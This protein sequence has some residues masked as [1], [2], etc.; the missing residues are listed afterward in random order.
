MLRHQTNRCPICRT[1]VESLLEIKVERRPAA[2]PK[3]IAA[4]PAPAAAAA[5]PQEG[6]QL[7]A[8]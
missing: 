4:L 7:A 3:E 6:A 8:Q 5:A 2:P 1:L